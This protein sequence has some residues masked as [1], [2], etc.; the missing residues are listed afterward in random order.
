[1]LDLDYFKDYNDRNGHQAGDRLLKEA[2]ARWG[3]H[4]RDTDLLARYGGEEFAVAMPDCDL[5]RASQVIER[6]RTA[7]PEG[8]KASAGVVAWDGEESEIQLVARADEAL[9]KAKRAGRDRVET[10]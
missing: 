6:I 2:A 5:A 8:E 4:V 3:A 10:A 7:T 9:Y 1:M